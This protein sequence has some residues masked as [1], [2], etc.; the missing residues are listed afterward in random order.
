MKRIAIPV[1]TLMFV[2]MLMLGMNKINFASYKAESLYQQAVNDLNNRKY[3]Q[4]WMAFAQIISLGEKQIGVNLY[5]KARS[6]LYFTVFQELIKLNSFGSGNYSL[7]LSHFEKALSEKISGGKPEYD[8]Q[9]D[10]LYP[11]FLVNKAMILHEMIL[12]DKKLHL[13]VNNLTINNRYE[14]VQMALLETQKELDIIDVDALDDF[15]K[16]LADRTRGFLDVMKE[17]NPDMFSARELSIQE[18]DYVTKPGFTCEWISKVISKEGNTLSVTT[19]YVSEQNRTG[20]EKGKTIQLLDDELQLVKR[21]CSNATLV[22]W[23]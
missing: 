1:I 11:Y 19:T 18:G 8:Q 21:I 15:G 6:Q 5:R 12:Q 7:M 23:R 3:P 4:A 13:P 22:G 14:Q 10:V 16:K 17:M 9:F 2:I 20:F